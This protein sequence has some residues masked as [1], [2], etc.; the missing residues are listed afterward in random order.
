[1]Q[2]ASEQDKKDLSKLLCARWKAWEPRHFLERFSVMSTGRRRLS[3]SPWL[4]SFRSSKDTTSALGRGPQRAETELSTALTP[5]SSLKMPVVFFLHKGIY[6][7]Q[8]TVGP[9]CAPNYTA[10]LLLGQCLRWGRFF[11]L[12]TP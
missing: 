12:G 5:I 7:M 1:M 3:R 2:S 8:E 11:M 4:V 9:N 10:C 6:G